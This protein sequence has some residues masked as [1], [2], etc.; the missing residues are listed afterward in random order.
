MERGGREGR[1]KGKGGLKGRGKER[2]GEEENLQGCFSI[3]KLPALYP[4]GRDKWGQLE[5]QSL[6]MLTRALNQ[7]QPLPSAQ[8]FAVF[9]SKMEVTKIPSHLR[10]TRPLCL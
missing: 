3:M 9:H 5:S 2:G 8:V 10:V 6:P 7:V 1:K 4:A